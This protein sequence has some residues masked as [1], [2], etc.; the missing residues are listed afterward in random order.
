[1][2]RCPLGQGVWVLI[3]TVSY[4]PSWGKRGQETSSGYQRVFD[5][6]RDGLDC[7][8]GS[9][10]MHGDLKPDNILFEDFDDDGCPTGVQ[11]A[12]FGISRKLS[13]LEGKF[14]GAYFM[15]SWHLP[16]TVFTRVE[17]PLKLSKGKSF[18]TPDRRIDECSF[19]LLMFRFFKRRVSSI[20]KD[21][22]KGACGPMGPGRKLMMPWDAMRARMIGFWKGREPLVLVEETCLLD[23]FSVCNFVAAE[24]RWPLCRPGRRLHVV[25]QAAATRSRFGRPLGTWVLGRM[26]AYGS[27]SV[28]GLHN[29]QSGVICTVILMINHH[30]IFREVIGLELF[31]FII[32]TLLAKTDRTYWDEAFA[33]DVLFGKN[34]QLLMIS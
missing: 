5:A 13:S 10:Y 24:C 16:G 32:P 15:G 28:G 21:V 27:F 18:F 12:D 4:P 23:R 22:G 34:P 8:H 9:G 3:W 30:P 1:M 2:C 26:T 14:D 25:T 6:L 11:L 33:N 17:D 7:M 31:N 19:A 20:V 29:P